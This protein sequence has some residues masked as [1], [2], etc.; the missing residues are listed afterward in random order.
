LKVE[1][2]VCRNTGRNERAF[3]SCPISW[4]I[5]EI[6]PLLS[7]NEAGLRRL[8]TRDHRLC[9]PRDLLGFQRSITA[10]IAG[11]AIGGIVCTTA[12]ICVGKDITS[13][14]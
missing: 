10:V 2:T 13:N 7:T 4:R 1:E 11:T 6:F 5:G 8:T 12:L 9:S 14:N 3:A